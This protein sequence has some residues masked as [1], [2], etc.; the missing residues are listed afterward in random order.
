MRSFGVILNCLPPAEYQSCIFRHGK[1]RTFN[2]VLICTTA[3]NLFC[4]WFRSVSSA[5]AF[6]STSVCKRETKRHWYT[7]TVKL[8]FTCIRWS[9]RKWRP[10][11]TW[12]KDVS[13]GPVREDKM[14]WDSS[15]FLPH[16]FFQKGIVVSHPPCKAVAAAGSRWWLHDWRGV[17]GPHCRGR[18]EHLPT[19][20][21]LNKRDILEP[22]T[23]SN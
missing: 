1:F 11:W 9:G 20:T 22:V 14:L 23:T 6:S 21:P 12:R 2:D 4:W 15:L 19:L 13:K 18:R 7:H 3:N 5:E 8:S 10:N 16:L 17:G